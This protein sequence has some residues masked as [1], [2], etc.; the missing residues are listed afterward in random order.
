MPVAGQLS[1][2]PIK[3]RLTLAHPM[4]PCSLNLC[5]MLRRPG[6]GFGTREDSADIDAPGCSH[7]PSVRRLSG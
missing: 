2:D 1:D 5:E 6:I 7:S 3:K 4:W